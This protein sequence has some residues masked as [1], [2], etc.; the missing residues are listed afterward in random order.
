MKKNVAKSMVGFWPISNRVIMMK[1]E[2]KPFNINIIQVYAPKQDH[3]DEEF[4]KFYQEIQGG[5]KYVKSDEV[6]F[7]MGDLDAK[8]GNEK[9][10]SIVGAHGQ[11]KRNERGEQMIHFCQRDKLLIPNTWFQQP[12]RKFTHGKVLEVFLG[13]R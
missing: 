12:A 8:V 7:V 6:I 9:Y 5:I 10:P 11:G 1:L 13:I 3:E 4:K 2:A